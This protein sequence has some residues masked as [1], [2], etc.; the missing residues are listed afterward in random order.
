M[1]EKQQMSDGPLAVMRELA[2]R[3]KGKISSITL[4]DV[5][6]CKSVS[7]RARPWEF[8]I[9]SGEPFSKQFRYSYRGRQISVVGNS[10]FLH[11][12]VKGSFPTQ[13]LSVNEMN[14]INPQL[15][16]AKTL[17]IDNT[18][19]YPLFTE[20][21]NLSPDQRS[22]TEKPEFRSLIRTL[23]LH[24]EEKLNIFN[25]A[26]SAYLKSPPIERV[27]GSIDG[28]IDLAENIEVATG[29][30]DFTVLPLQF[31]P[32]IPL[33]QKWA[34]ADD[35]NREDFLE[36]LPKAAVERFVKEVEPY[37]RAIDSYLDSFRDQPPS[38]QACALGRLAECAV[39]AKQ[40]LEA[41]RR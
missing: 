21:G 22:L 17:T 5:N 10:S 13:P 18:P 30:L 3:Y 28:I 37:L 26:I 16:Y 6:V 9:V 2:K 7:P 31:R 14:L 33:I 11:L 29:E 12:S 38:E 36:N 27:T 8:T 24:T 32:L 20:T 15:Q 34:I 35:S 19:P 23:N 40:Y 4:L 1:M 39:E 25:D 41:N